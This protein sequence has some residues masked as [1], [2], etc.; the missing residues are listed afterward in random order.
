MVNSYTIIRLKNRYGDSDVNLGL[1]FH[2]EVGLFR[3][4]PKPDEISDY[5]PYINL[6]TQ[7]KK[8]EED[9]EINNE[10]FKL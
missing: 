9:E 6:L 3:E 5:E 2:G 10:Y 4:L 1:S 7:D 8:E